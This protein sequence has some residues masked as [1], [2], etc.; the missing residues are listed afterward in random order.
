[1]AK[2]TAPNVPFVEARNVGAKQR[3]TAILIR[4]SSTTSEKGA[5]LGIANYHHKVGAPLES[6]HYIIDEVETYNCV[7]DKVQAYKSP[8][9]SLSVL[10]CAQPHEDVALWED[11]TARPVMYRAACLVANLIRIHN[12]RIRYLDEADQKRW[13]HHK[14]RRRGGLIVQVV[15]TWPY[16][17][18]L[19]DIRSHMER[20]DD[21]RNSA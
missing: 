7:P 19:D 2:Q 8:H 18:F 16:E 11:A 12:V 13:L 5:A 10:I 4:L 3:P 1:M 21:E 17:A 9:K 6:H 15:G 14:W 20:K